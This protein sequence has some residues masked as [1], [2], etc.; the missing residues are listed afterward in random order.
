M[1]LAIYWQ[2]L[3]GSRIEPWF[4]W[5]IVQRNLNLSV[6]LIVTLSLIEYSIYISPAKKKQMMYQIFS[7]SNLLL[8]IPLILYVRRA[9]WESKNT[10]TQRAI[11][12]GGSA[13]GQQ[14]PPRKQSIRGR[15]A[16]ANVSENFWTSDLSLNQAFT[17][18]ARSAPHN[19]QLSLSAMFRLWRTSSVGI[20][21]LASLQRKFLIF[22]G[23]LT[24]H[25]DVH[26]LVSSS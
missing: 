20:E 1:F 18:R 14:N 11:L 10:S 22:P 6:R 9:V 13:M 21:H 23:T 7:V 26:S 16:C 17:R 25:N 19:W 15:C 2:P 12:D 4:G 8:T 5:G 3:R 24:D